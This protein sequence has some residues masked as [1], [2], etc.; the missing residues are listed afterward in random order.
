MKPLRYDFEIH[1][2]STFSITLT[3]YANANLINRG[4]WSSLTTYSVDDVVVWKGVIYKCILAH[5]T[6]YEPPNVTYWGSVTP[7]DLST[8]TFS[9]KIRTDYDDE[10]ALATFTIAY[11]TDGTDGKIAL[12]LTAAQT[13]ALDFSKAVYDLEVTTGSTV[14]KWL[15]GKVILRKEATY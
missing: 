5:T 6:A 14:D 3:K 12:S 7:Q 9:A 8:S 2:G 1:Q 13:A 11:V 10:D 4:T 15:T